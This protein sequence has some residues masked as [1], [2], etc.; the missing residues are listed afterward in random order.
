MSVSSRSKTT[1][2]V[3]T[4][5]MVATGAP[6]AFGTVTGIER[7]TPDPARY[8]LPPGSGGRV[9]PDPPDHLVDDTAGRCP[10]SEVEGADPIGRRTEGRIADGRCRVRNSM[11]LDHRG[12][13]EC[14]GTR[15]Q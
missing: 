15:Q 4:W 10:T 8:Q 14:G 11:A 9:L 2:R 3:V 1:A 12:M 13:V 5:A 7:T 6:C